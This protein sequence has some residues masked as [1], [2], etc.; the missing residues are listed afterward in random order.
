ME[1][2]LEFHKGKTVVIAD[3]RLSTMKN[4]DQNVVMKSWKTV[5]IGTQREL[6]DKRGEYYT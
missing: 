2:P 1:N 3:H 5:E 4:A 6:T